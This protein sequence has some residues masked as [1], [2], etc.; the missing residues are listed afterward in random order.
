MTQVY[1]PPSMTGDGTTGTSRARLR[2]RRMRVWVGVGAV[3]LASAALV[4]LLPQPVTSTQP[5]AIDNAAG[6]GAMAVARILEDQGVTVT[7]VNTI[8]EAVAAAEAGSTLAV[9]GDVDL[10]TDDIDALLGTDADLVAVKFQDVTDRLLPGVMLG[11]GDFSPRNRTARCD[12]PD[13]VAAG[14]ATFASVM[15]VSSAFDG[16]ACF[17]NEDDA[18]LAD[19]MTPAA[20]VVGTQNGR[21]VTMLA[22]GTP[23]L[24]GHLADE[25]NAALALRV[26]GHNKNL[27]WFIPTWDYNGQT[28]EVGIWD[29]FPPPVAMAMLQLGVAGLIATFWYGRRLGPVVSE[30]LPVVVPAAEASRGRGR[31]Y[32][33]MRAHGRAAAALR[34]GSA[35]RIGSRLGLPRSAPARELVGAVAAATGRPPTAAE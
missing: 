15:W 24:N 13:A 32:R 26:L 25:G 29:L 21:T 35:L 10:M 30:R 8:D 6:D 3:L 27:V 5:Y 1:L 12:D 23:L 31:L 22:D 7:A 19:V 34:A 17:S 9:F 16:T 33:T 28:Q 11:T 4:L 14:T 18:D 2:W 20:M